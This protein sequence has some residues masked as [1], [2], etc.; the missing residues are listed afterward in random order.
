DKIVSANNYINKSRHTIKNE[1]RLK[2]HM[3]PPIGWLNDPNGLIYFKDRFHL[4]YQFNPYAS[5]PGKMCWGHFVS[6][7]LISY[8]DDGVALKPDIEDASAYSGGSIESDGKIIAFYTLHIENGKIKSEEVYKAV[9]T[10]GFCFD[11][12]VKVFDNERLPKNISRTD[13]RDPCPVK[14]GDNYFV[15]LGGKDVVS[16]K[17]VIIVLKGKNPD[18][19][20]YAFM[21]GPYYELG[22]M[23]ECPSYFRVGDKDVIVVS[24]CNVPERGNDFK[25]INSSVFIVGN[26]DFE[27]GKMEVEFIREIDKGDSF[28][29]P[30]FIRGMGKCVMI[31]WLE[32]WEKKYPTR[33]KNHGWVGAFTIPREIS[34]KDGEIYQTPVESLNKYLTPVE[35]GKIPKC[36]DIS[37]KFNGEGRLK[38]KGSD[39]EV[40][41]G[42]KSGVYLDT[43]LTN[44]LFGCVRR[45]NND[46][47]AC[48]VRILLDVSSIEVF[49]DGGREVISSRIYI[50]GSYNLEIDGG[51]SEIRIK[52]IGKK[53]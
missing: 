4:Y 53:Q 26:L 31:G 9:S 12:G 34:V 28:Y 8:V 43:N 13:F 35:D 29:A 50:D 51:I 32:M 40:V 7:D 37:F 47:E 41:V 3:M 23:G 30:Q 16:D 19:L 11:Q 39:G 44:N 15:F 1:Y 6:E 10:E 38:I 36:A 42:K 52:E 48:E 2:Y 46:Y 21:L 18:K 5:C 14:I 45:T 49:V 22:D 33:E 20:E 25:N 27:N 24:G 17:G